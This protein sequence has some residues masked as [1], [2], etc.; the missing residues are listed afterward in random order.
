MK[1][2]EKKM[3]KLFNFEPKFIK[4]LENNEVTLDNI[5]K[6]I[7][8]KMKSQYT[9]LGISKDLYIFNIYSKVGNNIKYDILPLKTISLKYCK[10]IL[11]KET[12]YLEYKFPFFQYIIEKLI[13]EIDTKIFFEK[14][15]Y[16]DSE[17]YNYLKG[18][19]F[20]YASINEIENIKDTFFDTKIKYILIVESI[21]KMEESNSGFLK[22]TV[23]TFNNQ[24]IFS[25]IKKEELLNKYLNKVNSELENM[26]NSKLDNKNIEYY[27]YNSLKKEK[28][29]IENIFLGKKTK[30][31]KDKEESTKIINKNKTKDIS[32]EIK[33]NKTKKEI[34]LE[35]IIDEVSYSEDFKNSG[36]LIKQKQLNGKT[37][38]LGVLIG[39]KNNKSFI[40][41]QIK[42]FGPEAHSKNFITKKSIK[43][44]IQPILIK[45]FQK[46]DLKITNWHYIMCLYF[47][48]TDLIQ[49]NQQL[50]NLCN[51]SDI[52]YIFY[53]PIEKKFYNK[54]KKPLLKLN[55]DYKTNID[56]E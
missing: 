9:N 34:N 25:K 49:Y 33:I 43:E 39:D 5:E 30:L 10:L 12:F 35:E 4:L 37:L 27:F 28:E 13:K 54:Q 32:K 17:L 42:F 16:Q 15:E 2:D 20:K 50:I 56:F 19:F 40:G 8:E 6:H 41:F 46:Y 11:E 21:V 1:E 48:S 36:I 31:E 53:N 51:S 14:N 26:K 38:D 23:E 47:N 7:T 18:Y 52:Q 3:Y 22:T 24:K 29:K 44:E 45:C 55:L